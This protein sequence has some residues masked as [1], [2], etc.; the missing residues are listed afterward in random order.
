MEERCFEP[1]FFGCVGQDATLAR[2]L[3]RLR[4]E[5]LALLGDFLAFCVCFEEDEEME[6]L[7][8]RLA[9][10]ELEDFRLLA[11]LVQAMGGEGAPRLQIR[12]RGCA[13][14][15]DPTRRGLSALYASLERIRRFCC[16]LEELIV[17]AEDAVARAALS[18]LLERRRQ[19]IEEI[20]AL[21]G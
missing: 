3:N 20:S 5:S 19:S 2:I 8:D 17:R 4:G 15:S 9:R 7:F 14:E 1:R 18:Y 16:A 10:R 12:T 13:S 6:A 11:R 21:V